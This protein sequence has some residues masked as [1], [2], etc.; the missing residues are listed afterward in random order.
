LAFPFYQQVDEDVDAQNTGSC[1]NQNSPMQQEVHLF[2]D[3][4]ILPTIARKLYLG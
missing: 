1:L 2:Q 3:N 4:G